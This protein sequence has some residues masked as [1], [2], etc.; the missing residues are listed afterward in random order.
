MVTFLFAF[1]G[2]MIGGLIINY[3][4]QG[5]ERIIDEENDK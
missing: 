4:L 5:P 1:S 3:I 2:A